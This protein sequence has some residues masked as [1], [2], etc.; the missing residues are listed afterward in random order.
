MKKNT[1]HLIQQLTMAIDYHER[2]A[3]KAFFTQTVD[4]HMTTI[5][6]LQAQLQVLERKRD[7][8]SS[9]SQ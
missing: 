4:I 5:K 2:E 1:D 3:S 8:C 9:R 6:S 7:S